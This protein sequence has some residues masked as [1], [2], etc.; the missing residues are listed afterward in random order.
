MAY[1]STIQMTTTVTHTV[2]STTTTSVT[3]TTTDVPVPTNAPAAYKAT[4]NA[5]GTPYVWHLVEGLGHR[6]GEYLAGRVCEAITGEKVVTR[7][8]WARLEKLCGLNDF[9][10][11]ELKVMYTVKPREW[12]RLVGVVIQHKQANEKTVGPK[13]KKWYGARRDYD[14]MED[15]CKALTGVPLPPSGYARAEKA[16]KQAKKEAEAAADM[17]YFACT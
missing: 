16:K 7:N 11:E 4:A 17:L 14:A 1:Q 8:A 3:T 10:D 2:T 9:D 13:A 5:A 6:R 12:Q 15:F